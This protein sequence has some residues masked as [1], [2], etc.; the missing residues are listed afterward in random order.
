[1][2]KQKVKKPHGIRHSIGLFFS[3]LLLVLGIVLNAA[4]GMFGGLVQ[5]FFGAASP[6]VNEADKAATL[7]AAAELARQVEA[8]GMVLVQNRNDTL[9]LSASIKQVNVFGWASTAWLGGGS[10]SGGVSKMDVDLLRALSD[11]GIA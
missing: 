2:S 10:G 8:E 5:T 9:P 4:W 7:S 11:Y 1:M 3:V 6:Q